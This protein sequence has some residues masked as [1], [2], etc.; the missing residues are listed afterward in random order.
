MPFRSDLTDRFANVKVHVVHA[1]VVV[2]AQEFR[3]PPIVAETAEREANGA[4]TACHG[5]TR[6]VEHL[7]GL[8]ERAPTGC[9][10]ISL[11]TSFAPG[12]SMSQTRCTCSLVH[13][14]GVVASFAS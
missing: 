11:K 8:V 9:F 6:Q 2:A 12:L 7:A 13:G 10:A 4:H 1:R 14:S 3:L 5:Q